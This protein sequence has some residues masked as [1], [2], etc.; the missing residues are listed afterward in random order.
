MAGEHT[1]YLKDPYLQL[2]AV[3]Q[4][5]DGTIYQHDGTTPHFANIVRTFLDEQF[6]ER[7]TE[8]D[9]RTSHGLPDHQM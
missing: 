6:P 8:E 7:R 1:W 9:H 2:Y 5:N 4:L 3:P